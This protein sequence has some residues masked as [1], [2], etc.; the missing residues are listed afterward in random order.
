MI[1]YTLPSLQRY[2]FRSDN[3]NR[4]A[5]VYTINKSSIVLWKLAAKKVMMMVLMN[6]N[7]QS[8]YKIMKNS[9]YR[10]SDS[11]MCVFLN[12]QMNP[13]IAA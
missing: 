5:F 13:R 6:M 1:N 10:F 8:T 12:S 3:H 11:F 2:M 7:S 9:L 4:I